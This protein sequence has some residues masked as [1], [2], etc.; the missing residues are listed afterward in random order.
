M[1]E[2]K[3]TDCGS[4]YTVC[5][6]NTRTAKIR[7]LYGCIETIEEA[8]VLSQYAMSFQRKNDNELVFIFPGWNI[9]IQ[10]RPEMLA[11]AKRLAEEYRYQ[12]KKEA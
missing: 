5:I 4:G 3:F 1:P 10:N 7:E 11:Y 8:Y 6:I 12:N 9:G 2:K